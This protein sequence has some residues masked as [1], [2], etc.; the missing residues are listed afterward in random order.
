MS[1]ALEGKEVSSHPL[2]LWLLGVDGPDDNGQEVR[3]GWED[4]MMKSKGDSFYPSPH[5][6]ERIWPYGTEGLSMGEGWTDYHFAKWFGIECHLEN[7]QNA[8][9]Y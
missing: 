6:T 8:Q 5:R 2:K 9:N 7:L 4:K 1:R 3:V